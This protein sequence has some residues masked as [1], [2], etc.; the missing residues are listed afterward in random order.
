M[1]TYMLEETFAVV[2][3]LQSNL[4]YMYADPIYIK[5]TPSNKRTAERPLFLATDS[6]QK[7][8]VFNR[9]L[10]GMVHYLLG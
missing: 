9:H 2:I 5:R 3:N 4:Y 7:S 1:V 6:R 10:L 8:P